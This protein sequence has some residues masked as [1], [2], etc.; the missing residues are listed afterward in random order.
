MFFA[1]LDVPAV[2]AV[3]LLPVP[4]ALRT[5]LEGRRPLP[6]TRHRGRRLAGS[7]PRR[8]RLAGNGARDC[9]RRSPRCTKSS[10]ALTVADD[11][12][13]EARCGS[14]PQRR[15]G[16]PAKVRYIGP[17]TVVAGQRCLE[18]AGI[19]DGALR[20]VHRCGQLG[21]P[22]L[23]ADS[24]RRIVRRDAAA[25]DG[26]AERIGGHSLRT[27]SAR[28]FAADRVSPGGAAAGGRVEVADDA[29]GVRAGRVGAALYGASSS[30]R[31]ARGRSAPPRPEAC[32][33]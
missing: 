21:A 16:D 29:C 22:S 23:S 15:R 17:R 9:V 31:V 18:A 30:A 14:A 7:A 26:I 1:K 19:V 5:Q 28:E 4:S 24:I 32:C 6:I 2:A 8:G 13:A 11:E 10:A 33:P 25:V 27:G 3:T 20:V 12:A